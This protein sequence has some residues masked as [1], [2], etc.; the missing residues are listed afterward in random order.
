MTGGAA[1]PGL[2]T[3]KVSVRHCVAVVWPTPVETT[4]PFKVE[5]EE[6]VLVD[7]PEMVKDTK[8][9]RICNGHLMTL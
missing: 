7:G 4:T 3:A 5:V 1:P 8:S 2:V 9:K 6:M